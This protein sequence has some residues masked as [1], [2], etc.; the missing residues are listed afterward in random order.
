MTGIYCD[1]TRVFE[2]PHAETE[3]LLFNLKGGRKKIKIQL[4]PEAS[5]LIYLDLMHPCDHSNG[6]FL[7][8]MLDFIWN[9][10]A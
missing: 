4:A 10:F 2:T 1:L 6:R 7:T 3:K 5:G 9:N 8:V